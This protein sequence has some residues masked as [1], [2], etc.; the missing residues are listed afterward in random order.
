MLAKSKRQQESRTTRR[1]K[2]TFLAVLCSTSS[3][4]NFQANR[5]RLES[6]VLEP[7]GSRQALST[8]VQFV[9]SSNAPV[10]SEQ[11][12]VVQRIGTSMVITD[13]LLTD[14]SGS[15]NLH[16][17]YCLPMYVAVRGATVAIKSG[18]DL[19]THRQRIQAVGVQ[20]L[21]A[22]FGMPDSRYLGYTKRQP[23]CG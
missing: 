20:S 23:G 9:N 7:G 13:V 1:M 22:L 8:R 10:A 15:I 21:S 14:S 11:T 3:C 16:G 12:Y 18:G 19:P 5:E 17:E 6:H 4:G 2:I